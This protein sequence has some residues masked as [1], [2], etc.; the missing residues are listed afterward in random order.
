MHC[1]GSTG[2]K[3]P[4]HDVTTTTTVFLCTSDHSGQTTQSLSRL[5][6]NISS[7]GLVL[8]QCTQL[9]TLVKLEHDYNIDLIAG[10][11]FLDS[12]LAVHGYETHLTVASVPA[13]HSSWQAYAFMVPGLFLT[14]QTN[15]PQAEGDIN[16]YLSNK[17]HLILC[18][19]KL[20]AV[21]ND[22]QQE[23]Q[24]P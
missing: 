4:E 20:P 6:I 2:S 22:Q 15:F 18:T 21:V 9:R 24:T 17:P 14:I 19:D 11:S 5:T 23:V 1:T 10:A 8:S 16:L 7:R 13:A 12:S 3:T